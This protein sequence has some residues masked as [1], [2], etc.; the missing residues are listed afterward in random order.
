MSE[1]FKV[2]APKFG[3]ETLIKQNRKHIG[4]A[5]Q[6]ILIALA[7]S[8][9]E[10]IIKWSVK[11][12]RVRRTLV[13]HRSSRGS[14]RRNYIWSSLKEIGSATH[15]DS[16]IRNPPIWR[17]QIQFRKKCKEASGSRYIGGMGL[18]LTA[19]ADVHRTRNN[20]KGSLKPYR[21]RTSSEV[22]A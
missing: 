18:L 4:S 9:A 10:T 1:L 19:N 7:K 12:Y 22:W 5:E 14:D 17:I 13:S 20:I 16:S 15:Q 6:R 2:Q 3:A 21:V 8:G 11:S